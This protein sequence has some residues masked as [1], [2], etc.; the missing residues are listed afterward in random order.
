MKYF[1]SL[2]HEWMVC[3]YFSNFWTFKVSVNESLHIYPYIK[4]LSEVNISY[5]N[6]LNSG[7]VYIICT[8]K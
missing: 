6:T 2:T 1:Q 5:K 3:R 4:D 7:L 8:E